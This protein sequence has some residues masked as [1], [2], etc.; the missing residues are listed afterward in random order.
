[1]VKIMRE[2]KSDKIAAIY[3]AVQELVLEGEDLVKLR[4]SD[5]ASRAGIGKGT[6]YD[7]FSSRE[8]II[9]KALVQLSTSTMNQLIAQLDT[10][11]CFEDKM[12]LLF[13]GMEKQIKA[14]TC[15]IKFISMLNEKDM[16]QDIYNGV[17]EEAVAQNAH[18]I[19]LIRYLL[20]SGKEEGIISKELSQEYM[21]MSFFSK[22][23]AY[24]MFTDL[25][26]G[27]RECTGEVFKRELYQG[28][29]REFGV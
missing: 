7:Y 28:I 12:F 29:C 3:A 15:I 14:R 9:V 17:I 26:C 22:L 16:F 13:D 19:R 18:P 25:D 2:K 5:I 20:E 27:N 21:E 10:L 11:S 4:V 6:V 24:I 1:M 23:I 8:E